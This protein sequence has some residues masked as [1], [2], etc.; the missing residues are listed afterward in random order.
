MSL[1]SNSSKQ[2][3]SDCMRKWAKEIGEERR[4]GVGSVCLALPFVLLLSQNSIYMCMIRGR[5]AGINPREL[6]KELIIYCA[7]VISGFKGH[8]VGE[9]SCFK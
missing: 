6:H 3:M 1:E 4:D 2:P 8:S 9:K 5:E 7:A